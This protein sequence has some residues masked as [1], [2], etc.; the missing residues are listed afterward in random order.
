MKKLALSLLAVLA[1]CGDPAVKAREDYEFA[2]RYGSREDKCA[3]AIEAKRLHME[4][5]DEL[6][7]ISWGMKVEKDCGTRW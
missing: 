4:R 1:A 2:E 6:D 5:R 7:T 3:A